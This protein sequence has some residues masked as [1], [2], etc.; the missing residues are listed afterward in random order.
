MKKILLAEDDKSILSAL[1]IRLQ[2]AGYHVVAVPDG[3][4]GYLY[5]VAE[6]P[7]LILMDIFMPNATGF[8]VAAELEE[9]GLGGVPVIFMTASRKPD[10]RKAAEKMG[11]WF[12]EKPFDTDAL[13]TAISEELDPNSKIAP[14]RQSLRIELLREPNTKPPNRRFET[15]EPGGENPGYERPDGRQQTRPSDREEGNTLPPK[16]VFG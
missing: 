15:S 1:T 8:Q 3:F 11:A 7:D 16:A 14:L 6:R 12:F 9:A 10:L 13:M 4:R 5:S 2:N